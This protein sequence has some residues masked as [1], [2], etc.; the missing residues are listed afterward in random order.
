LKFAFTG[1]QVAITFGPL[2][3]D[4]TLI[5]YRIDGQDWL[6][7]NVTTN[8]TQLLVSPSTPG[9]NLTNPVNPSTFEMRVT[10]WAYGVQISKVHVS[11]G[12]KLIKTPDFDRTIEFIGDSLSSGYGASLEGLS[13]YAYGL[14]AGLG[15]TE[16]SITAFPGI[17][18]YDQKCYGNPRG[19]FYQW[20]QTSDT[21]DRAIR[22]YGTEPEPWD[23][24]KHPDADI[25]V[26][27][28]G[29]NDANPAN[30]A[31]GAGYVA[32]YKML[33][34]GIH[35]M[36]PKAQ[37]ILIVSPPFYTHSSPTNLLKVH[38]ARLGSSRQLLPTIPRLGPRNLRHLRVFQL[39][40][41]PPKSSSL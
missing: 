28:L 36:W 13:S 22:L 15:N 20:F 5:G 38:L 1:Q 11:Q 26:I 35:A 3:T 18:L 27:N 40:S 19:Q 9:I 4:T 23:F 17:C 2:T 41:L 39:S 32:Q 31:P 14:A 10:N 33:I 7:T 6:F 25:V 30:N 29:T 12:E 21:S 34:E 37:V 8:A 16:Y 24:S